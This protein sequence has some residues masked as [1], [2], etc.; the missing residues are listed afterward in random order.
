M[1]QGYSSRKKALHVDT[2]ADATPLSKAQNVQAAQ[3]S[4]IKQTQ[5]A[6]FPTMTKTDN[7]T[8]H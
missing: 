2:C 4:S 3:T 6:N 5:D 8:A 1:C 7:T